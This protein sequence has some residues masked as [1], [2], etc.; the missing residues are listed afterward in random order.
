VRN[1]L[2]LKNNFSEALFLLTQLDIKDGNL[3]S[4]IDTTRQIITLEPNNPTRYYQMGVLLAANK[5]LEGAT[6][7]YEAAIK[8]DQNF[9][10]ARYMLALTYL[11]QKRLDDALVQLRIVR[12]TNQ[13]N[14]QLNN[15]VSQL[16][17]NGLPLA[18]T[19][20]L[21]GAVSEEKPG[22]QNGDTVTTPTQPNTDLVTPVNTPP[23]QE[24]EDATKQP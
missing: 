20:G 24:G 6:K 9:A 12:E 10:N 3:Q 7:A 4:A 8:I 14:E 11:D 23:Q 22:Q 18:P 16:E 5:D 17:Q 21:G 15:L 1:A 19:D 13:D 2:E